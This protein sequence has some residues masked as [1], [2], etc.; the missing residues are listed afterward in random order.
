MGLSPEGEEGLRGEE[1]A[2]LSC[3]AGD[4]LGPWRELVRTDPGGPRVQGLALA[5][6]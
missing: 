4:A 2:R 6:T 1:E 3:L 5:C